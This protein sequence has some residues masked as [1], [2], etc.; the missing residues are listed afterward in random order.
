MSLIVSFPGIKQTTLAEVGGK[1]YSLIRMVEA[2]LPVPPGA[3]L[4]TEFFAPWFDEIQ[5]S[6]TWTALADAMPDKWA[7]LCNELKALCPA[8]PLVATQRQAME[9][10]RENVAALGDGALFAVRTALN[11]VHSMASGYEPF[12]NSE[13]LPVLNQGLR[14]PL[15]AGFARFLESHENTVNQIGEAALQDEVDPYDTHP[16]LKDRLAALRRFPDGERQPDD[17][18]PAIELL[19]NIDELECQLLSYMLGD[20]QVAGYQGIAWEDVGDRVYPNVWQQHLAQFGSGLR[21]MTI[22]EVA[23]QFS[24]LEEVG[25]ELSLGQV[26]PEELVAFASWTLSVA[27][28]YALHR[29]GWSVRTGPGQ[30]LALEREGERIEPFSLFPDLDKGD[31]T[32]ESWQEW[33]QELGIED[34]PL[35]A[36]A[37]AVRKVEAAHI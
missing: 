29:E 19:N 12:L 35:V 11:K 16:P 20:P 5:S 27:M 31:R 18:R 3:V 21:D 36:R 22:G 8:L 1:G 6:A 37:A 25:K 10:L 14:P 30:P 9:D 2:G 7:T 26:P 23:G 28:S 32:L 17:E 34:V 33:L 24:R 4:T 13:V 15:V